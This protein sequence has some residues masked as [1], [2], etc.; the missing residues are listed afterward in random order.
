MI[1][2][3]EIESS[4]RISILKVIPNTNIGKD[5]EKKNLTTQEY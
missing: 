2:K 5:L 3:R 4:S 1:E